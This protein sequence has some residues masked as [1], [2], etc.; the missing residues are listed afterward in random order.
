MKALFCRGYALSA[1][2]D[3]LQTTI[4]SDEDF[5]YFTIT[6]NGV[7]ESNKTVTGIYGIEFDRSKTGRGDLLVTVQSV[8]ENW[9][10]QNVK[11]YIDPDKDIGGPNPLLP[12]EDFTGNGYEKQLKL[13]T[14]SWPMPYATG[15]PILSKLAVPRE[16]LENAR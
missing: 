11:V 4:A 1:C 9:S 2:L 3:I 15:P 13:E 10:P 5:Y 16:L 7:S 8:A 14:A 12:D 6:L